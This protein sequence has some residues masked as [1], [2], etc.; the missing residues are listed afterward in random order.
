V[1]LSNERVYNYAVAGPGATTLNTDQRRILNLGNPENAKFGGAVFGAVGVHTGSGNSNYNA[2]QAAATRKLARGLQMS[3][4]YTWSHNIDNASGRRVSSRYDPRQDR[5]NSDMDQRHRYVLSLVYK[6]PLRGR[7]LGGW[8]VSA[9]M[10]LQSGLWVSVADSQ[11]RCLCATGNQRADALG[12]AI[13][14][15]D[16]RSTGSVPGRPNS[17]FDGTGGG[18]ATGTP[19]PYFRRVGSGPSWALGA[20]RYGTAGRNT[21]LTPGT[22]NWN[23]AAVK[24]TRIREGHDLEFRAEFFNAFNHTQFGFPDASVDSPNFGRITSASAPRIVQLGLRY[25]F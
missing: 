22:N 7:I 5:G 17:W 11:D 23:A 13:Q 2:L 10:T 24:K 21:I 16:P 25:L 12:V 3:H 4:A 6:V 20:G 19:N 8:G 15:L 9:L 18:S 14:Y 1:K